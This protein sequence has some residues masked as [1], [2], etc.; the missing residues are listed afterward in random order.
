MA[1]NPHDNGWHIWSSHGTVLFHIA[2]HPGCTIAD[3]ADALCLTQRTIWG[4]VGDLRRAN[5]LDVKR[6]GR[7]HRYLVRLDADFRHPTI[8][9]VPLSTVFGRLPAA[10][11]K[12]A[13]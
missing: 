6:D 8:E 4:V 3:I 13:A 2:L 10:R 9:R 5:M 12:P 11:V 1:N 7:R